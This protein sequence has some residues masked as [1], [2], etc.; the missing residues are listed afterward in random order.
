[1]PDPT[2]RDLLLAKVD[3]LTAKH[4]ELLDEVRAVA[5]E[6]EPERARS[7]RNAIT[8]AA[9]SSTRS[10]YAP[11]PAH[12]TATR[13]DSPGL[14]AGWAPPRAARYV[15]ANARRS[16][17]CGLCAMAD[18]AVVTGRWGLRFPGGPSRDCHPN[19]PRRAGPRA[20]QGRPVT[21]ERSEWDR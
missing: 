13:S 21:G 10:G 4:A 9:V 20:R 2:V 18:G 12:W 8:M 16:Y 3:E 19:Q 14:T 6:L 17:L 15:A 1:M 5:G 7:C 11:T